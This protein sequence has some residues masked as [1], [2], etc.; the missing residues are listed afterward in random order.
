M[1]IDTSYL[2]HTLERLI[3]TPSPVGNTARGLDLVTQI[4]CEQD[5]G[6]GFDLHRSPKGVLTA[7]IRGH[8]HAAPRAITAHIDTI[9][10]MAK[11]INSNG[12]LKLAQL[13]SFDWSAIENENVTVETAAGQT[14]SGT[15]LYV[16]PSYHVHT[17]DDRIDQKPRSA[18][19]MEVRLDARVNSK[20]D[21][22]KLGIEIGDFVHFE[23]RFQTVDGFIKSRFLDDK[24][25]LASVFTALKGI[26]EAGERPAQTTTIHIANYEEV[27]HGAATGMPADVVDV[28]AIDVAPI[29]RGQNSTEFQCSICLLDD[30]G[31]YD[32]EL[33]ARLRH[34]ARAHDI[35]LRPDLYVQFSSD[36]K[37]LWK[38][39]FDARCAL[40]GPGVDNTHGYERTHLDAL[41]DTTKLITAWLRT[42]EAMGRADNNV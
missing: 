33:S 14:Y 28:L 29:G 18:D 2:L 23:P 42:D 26:W 17:P 34:L 3:Q 32:R 41:V 30:D 27:C 10:A 31:P 1:T 39:G 19:S 25:C 11:E 40:I 7:T 15:V 22:R 8:S 20:D 5:W 36:A 35:N 6:E 13:G 38:S 9:G 4:L 24:A 12:R 16:N 21:T 37:A